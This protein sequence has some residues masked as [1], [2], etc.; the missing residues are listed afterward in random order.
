M[1]GTDHI[2]K[3]VYQRRRE[4]V[5]LLLSGIFLGSL[6]MLNILGITRFIDLSMY[7]GIPENSP[8]HFSVAVGVLAYPITFLCT[9]FISEIYGRKRAN[10]LV[11][12]GLILNAWVLFVLWL[13]GTLDPPKALNEFGLLSPQIV[14]GEVNIP[15]GYAFYEI[16]QATFA[17]TFASMLAYLAAQFCDV[18]V[19]HFFKKLTKGKHLWL[20]N[21]ASTLSSQLIDSSVVILITHYVAHALPIDPDQSLGWQ[22][23]LFIASSYLFKFCFALIDTIPFYFG[24]RFFRKWLNIQDEVE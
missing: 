14:D 5:F 1:F 4:F 18:Q 24:V 19:F 22:L 3:T 23:F 15:Y 2:H 13:G 17:A 11:L 21:N 12:I 10:M 20:R 8:V 9:D 6:T 7:F 16:R